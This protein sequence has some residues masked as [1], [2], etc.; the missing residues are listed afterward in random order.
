M[1]SMDEI[2]ILTIIPS[3]PDRVTETSLIFRNVLPELQ[4]KIITH[5]VWLVYTPDSLKHKESNNFEKVLDIHDY[6]N[7]VELLEIEKPDLVYAMANYSLID[8]AISCAAKHLGIPVLSKFMNRIAVVSVNLKRSLLSRFF[9]KSLPTDEINSQEKFMRRGRFFLY[10]WTFLLHTLNASNFGR[11]QS[12]IIAIKLWK[13][14]LN[15]SKDEGLPEFA[16]TLHWLESDARVE[17]LVQLGFKPD[18]LVVTG[19]PLYDHVFL[20]LK[21]LESLEQYHKKPSI[22][23]FPVPYYEHGIITKK[24]SEICFKKTVKA[25]A[26]NKNIDLKIKL[27]PTSQQISYYEKITEKIDSDIKIFQK[28]DALEHIINSDLVISYS[29]FSS[30]HTYA[31]IYNKPLILCNFFKFNK[32]LLLNKNIAIECKDI[33]TINELISSSLKKNPIS[34]QSIQDYINNFFYKTDGKSSERLANE[35]I[36]L[37]KKSQTI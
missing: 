1:K 11:M 32:G 9:E 22:T 30:V 19:N 34:Q 36:N 29:G 21:N 26:E 14:F 5:M 4:K 10:K 3:L 37:I 23:F 27:H 24:E 15:I 33:R 7:F 31:L 18:S 13:Y 6:N 25:L 28:G 20:K 35:I 2:K 16:N 8:Y 12:L 17:K